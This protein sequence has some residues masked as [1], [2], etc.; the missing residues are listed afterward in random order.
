M[1]FAE[2]CGM[3]NVD[4]PKK[5]QKE[6]NNTMEEKKFDLSQLYIIDFVKNIG[7]K[8]NIFAIIYLLL[9]V[10]IITFLMQMFE[11]NIWL[12][13]LYSI[14]LYGITATIALSPVGE[15]SATSKPTADALIFCARGIDI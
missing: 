8:K 9:N 11:E 14:L 5:Q 2:Y 1:Q 3:L 4:Y 15:T 6:E 10:V 12:C 7:H 13:L